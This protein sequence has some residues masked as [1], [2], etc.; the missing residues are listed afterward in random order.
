MYSWDS[1][2]DTLAV[3]EPLYAHH[4]QKCPELYRPYRKQ[5]LAEQ[6]TDGA[7]VLAKLCEGPQNSESETIL[8]AKHMAKQGIGLDVAKLT[9]A[10]TQRHIILIRNPMKQLLSF[11]EKRM[12]T[13]AHGGTSL[14]ELALPQ[15]VEIFHSLKSAAGVEPVVVDYDDLL[16]APEKMLKALCA[17]LRVKFDPAMLSWQAGPKSCDGLWAKYWSVLSYYQL[18]QYPCACLTTACING[19]TM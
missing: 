8:F 3:D 14:H 17:Q 4:L 1:R 18:L 11:A 9:A 13:Q 16:A 19:A 2:G 12:D 5:L 6:T 15:L 7:A 10:P